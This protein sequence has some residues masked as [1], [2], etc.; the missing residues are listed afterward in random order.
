MVRQ[1]TLVIHSLHG[2]GAERTLVTMANHWAANGDRVTFIT[3]AAPERYDYELAASVVRVC[4]DGMQDSTTTLRAVINNFRRLVRLRRAIRDAKG[5]AVIS[6]TDKMNVLTLL[7][8]V[9]LRKRVVICERVD[10]RRHAIGRSWSFLRRR[11]YAWCD[12]LVVQ[13]EGVRDFVSGFVPKR[14]IRVI[15]NAVANSAIAQPD[16]GHREQ[17]IVAMGRLESQKGFDLLL[18]AFSQIVER[19]PGWRL[20]IFGDGSQRELLADQIR[21]LGLEQSVE[22]CGWVE[23]PD[24]WI[25]QSELFVLSSRYEGFPNA[26]LEAM[27]A[28][29]PAVSFD[30][31]S[32]PS[33]IIRHEVD[34]LL[35]PDGDVEGLAQAI[36]RVLS[37]PQERA[38]FG[39]RARDVT[40]RFSR[41]QYFQQWDAILSPAAHDSV[42]QRE[43]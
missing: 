29:V 4:L 2:G 32:G 26:L 31:E 30:C 23:S 15:A 38:A 6:F 12:T 36:D 37:N 22:L 42:T 18:E 21:E 40:T 20:K 28:G 9:G 8:C 10:P 33:E 35:V 11:T 5:D 25:N 24:R 39:Q 34:G 41:E 1:L 17:W 3:L 27:A 43:A 19:H 14:K 13:T 16:G 7:A